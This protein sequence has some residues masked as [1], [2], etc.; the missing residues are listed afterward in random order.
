MQ[1]LFLSIN[2]PSNDRLPLVRD[3]ARGG[4]YTRGRSRIIAVEPR[5]WRSSRATKPKSE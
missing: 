3:P 1:T 4:L 2:N 5:A